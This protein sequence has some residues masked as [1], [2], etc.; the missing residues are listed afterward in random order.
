MA[1]RLPSNLH[2]SCRKT[3]L[4]C[5]QLESDLA[6]RSI[7]STNQLY[8]F[9]DYLP[10]ARSKSERADIL[11]DFLLENRASDGKS[12]FPIFLRELSNR[13]EEDHLL[14]KELSAHSGEIV[15]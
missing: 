3:L 8:P 7:F 5:S 12:T 2:N 15:H 13:Y 6:L 9:R 1:E 4:K 14:R 11:L 10:N